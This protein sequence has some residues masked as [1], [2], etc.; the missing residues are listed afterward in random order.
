MLQLRWEPHC[1]LD[2]ATLASK[3][4]PP[5]VHE[6]IYSV[7]ASLIHTCH[8]D[9]LSL[10]DTED[11]VYILGW[12][13]IHSDNYGTVC[14]CCARAIIKEFY[15]LSLF[16]FV[17]S[18]F[19]IFGVLCVHTTMSHSCGIALC[20]TTHAQYTIGGNLRFL[21]DPSSRKEFKR[22]VLDVYIT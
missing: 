10:Q 1:T 7:A 8:H 21:N 15:A 20:P 22:N 3:A 14:I 5:R 13:L 18:V 12:N 9:T 4:L 6:Y 17:L 19:A 16:N 11:S 2:V